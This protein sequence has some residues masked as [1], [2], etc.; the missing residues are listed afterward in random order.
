MPLPFPSRS[1]ALSAL[2]ILHKA[3]TRGVREDAKRLRVTAEPTLRQLAKTRAG[4]ER[5]LRQVD[6]RA[7]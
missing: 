4:L 3:A 7:R 1:A 6:W 2:D 5:V